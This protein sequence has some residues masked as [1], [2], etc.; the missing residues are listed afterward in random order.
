MLRKYLFVL[1][2]GLVA[3]LGS[4]PLIHAQS[5]AGGVMPPQPP[6]Q[7]GQPPRD[8]PEQAAGLQSH[9]SH[10]P[11]E[12]RDAPYNGPSTKAP[13][14]LATPRSPQE[15]TQVAQQLQSNP[16]VQAAHQVAQ[17]AVAARR[18]FGQRLR[19]G[20]LPTEADKQ[21]GQSYEIAPQRRSETPLDGLVKLLTAG[22]SA[23]LEPVAE[24]VA[25]PDAQAYWGGFLCAVWE[26]FW[27]DRDQWGDDA[28]YSQGLN[29]CFPPANNESVAYNFVSMDLYK[30]VIYFITW[31]ICL[32][33][34]HWYELWPACEAIFVTYL[35][36]G[37]GYQAPRAYY[38]QNLSGAYF[39]RVYGHIQTVGGSTGGQYVDSE[40]I[41]YRCFQGGGT[42][43]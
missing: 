20:Q 32:G 31:D 8:H 36:C 1:M 18:A 40:V 27:L 25:E 13:P 42:I 6:A 2:L 19:S 24:P 3:L 23:A 21:H 30:C 39:L 28:F 34:Q 22:A 16:A 14:G 35:W 38:P 9:G 4:A 41:P 15:A 11:P 43:C 12:I 17:G 10:L 7:G 37:G 33:Q 26:N 5:P 29:Y